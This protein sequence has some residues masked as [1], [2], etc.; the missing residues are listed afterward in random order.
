VTMRRRRKTMEEGV[1]VL[2]AVV[3][4]VGMRLLP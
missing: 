2:L 3:V 4:R 1:G